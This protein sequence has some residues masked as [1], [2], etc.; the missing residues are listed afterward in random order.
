MI[1]CGHELYLSRGLIINT[2]LTHGNTPRVNELVR[3][4][5]IYLYDTP[6]PPLRPQTMNIFKSE[7]SF[8]KS[9]FIYDV[10]YNGRVVWDLFSDDQAPH[11]QH[12]SRSI[13]YSGI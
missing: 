11:L 10:L 8:Q 7:G 2:D 6:P 13:A 9:H 3:M 4:V 5:Q 12:Q 1:D